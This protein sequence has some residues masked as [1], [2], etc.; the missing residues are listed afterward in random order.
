MYRQSRVIDERSVLNSRRID[1]RHLGLRDWL[2]KHTVVVAIRTVVIRSIPACRRFVIGGRRNC[3]YT[4]PISND[5]DISWIESSAYRRLA[6]SLSEA[7][8]A[9]MIQSFCVRAQRS[10]GIFSGF[11]TAEH[12]V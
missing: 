4:I 12:D 10:Q 7:V 5:E 6:R 9:V 11:E 8:G 1:L 2:S 3:G